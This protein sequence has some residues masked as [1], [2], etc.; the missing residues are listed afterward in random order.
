MK[1]MNI[2]E[3]D[4]QNQI[5][6]YDRMTKVLNG[7]VERTG[8]YAKTYKFPEGSYELRFYLKL[9]AGQYLT[10]NYG[11]MSVGIYFHPN[12][13]NPTLPLD[14][15]RKPLDLFLNELIKFEPNLVKDPSQYPVDVLNKIEVKI[16][17]LYVRAGE[18][19]FDI[20]ELI[21]TALYN[22]KIRGFLEPLGEMLTDPSRSELYMFAPIELPVFHE[23][24]KK[25]HDNIIKRT[26][27]IVK[28]YQKGK[29]RGYTYDIG[30]LDTRHNSI[31]LL[32]DYGKP[33]VVDG[34]IQPNIKAHLT[35]MSP[36]I[37]GYNRWE[38][39]DD[40]PL[41]ETEVKEFYE[42][43]NKVFAKY[44]IKYE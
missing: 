8:H 42:H 44:N 27:T 18:C 5:E 35:M 3:G 43:M 38:H 10:E 21:G 9:D 37:N 22:I 41:A 33:P 16:Y 14:I 25:Y 29:W 15:I 32:T 23:D 2:I 1:L 24:F 31:L 13:D 20:N 34:V 11:S 36:I 6:T 17:S 28:A 19:L 30:N 4:D 40:Y 39:K 26:K 12:M 7:F